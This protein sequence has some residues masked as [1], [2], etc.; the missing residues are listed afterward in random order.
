MPRENTA[1]RGRFAP[2]PSGPMHLGSLIA[3]VASYL[4]ARHHQGTWLVRMED[5]DPPREEIGAAQ[6]ILNSLQLHGLCWDEDVLYQA[7][8]SEAYALALTT[9]RQAGLLFACD[10]SRT[11]LRRTGFCQGACRT[12]QAAINGTQSLRIDVPTECSIVFA[13]A[14]W[15][16]QKVDLGSTLQDFILRRKDGLYAYQLAVVVDDAAQGIT[17]IVRG[18]DLLDSTARQVYLQQCLGLSTPQYS[19][20]PVITHPDGNKFS[21]QTRAPALQ[22]HTAVDNLRLALR[23]LDQ[24]Q[25]PSS[26]HT[27]EELLRWATLHWSLARVPARMAITID[28]LSR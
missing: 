27:A 20:M 10:C 8:R 3:A 5:L 4:D 21:K 28:S 14:R 13:D 7:S 19:H 26:L 25:P 22:N 18:S 1:Y 2:S 17:H 15:G 24:P 16:P 9:L 23:F 11:S 12:R 6:S